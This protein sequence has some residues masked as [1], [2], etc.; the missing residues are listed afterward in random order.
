MCVL[1]LAK[2]ARVAFRVRHNN[3]DD[4]EIFSMVGGSSTLESFRCFR[5]DDGVLLVDEII[6]IDSNGCNIPFR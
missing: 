4:D 3:V 1:Q 2:M 6:R 5:F